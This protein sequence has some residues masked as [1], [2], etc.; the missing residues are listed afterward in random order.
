MKE[1]IWQTQGE[2]FYYLSNNASGV[3]IPQGT[4]STSPRTELSTPTQESKSKYIHIYTDKKI[5]IQNIQKLTQHRV[6]GGFLEH[7]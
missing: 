3:A 5:H 4:E 1:R 6:V 7:Q 2:L